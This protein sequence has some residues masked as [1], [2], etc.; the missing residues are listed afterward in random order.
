MER[1]PQDPEYPF[2]TT[3]CGDLFQCSERRTTCL[4]CDEARCDPLTVSLPG[5]P[6]TDC[7]PF[8]LVCDQRRDCPDGADESHCGDIVR[9]YH[10]TPE[11]DI[12]ATE[13][14]IY[15]ASLETCAA[16]CFFHPEKCQVFSYSNSSG[17]G[18]KFAGVSVSSGLGIQWR[19]M[20]RE[21]FLAL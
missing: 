3:C 4:Q 18:V 8:G 13:L 10:V 5:C 9:S 7:Q 12:T 2:S 21:V 17:D 11:F 6:D 20:G 1:W 16:Y 14:V 19:W 15:G